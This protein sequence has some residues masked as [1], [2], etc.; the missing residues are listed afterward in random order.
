MP[1]IRR[2]GAENSAVRARLIEAAAELIREQGYASVT[3]SRLAEAVGLKRHI[4]HYYFG[5]IDEVFVE[6][7]RREGEK[8]HKS[9]S[10]ALASDDPLRVIWEPDNHFPALTLEFFA[11]AIRHKSLREEVAH[12]SEKFRKMQTEAIQRY[13]KSKGIT[14]PVPPEAISYVIMGISRLISADRRAG[15][16]CGHAETKKLVECWIAQFATGSGPFAQD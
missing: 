11:M 13:I 6:V 2:R 5:K 15:I 3:T 16:D 9:V 1:Q 14:T 7:L 10:D 12:Y 8:M 4:V